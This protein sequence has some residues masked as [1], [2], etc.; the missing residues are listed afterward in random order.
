MQII[1]TLGEPLTF[2]TPLLAIATW[3]G[4]A[5][6]EQL[7]PLV[8]VGDW[9]SRPK[10]TL[11]LYPRGAI[12]AKRLLLLGLG[13]RNEATTE[14]L[15]EAGA[16]AAQQA[17]ELG[18]PELALALPV[19]ELLDPAVVSQALAEGA[20]LGQYRFNT[21]RTG[22]S[23]EQT[24]SVETLTLLTQS[25]T[26]GYERGIALAQ[27]IADGTQLARDL[28]NR[29][30]N[31]VVPAVLGATAEELGRHYGF[32]VTVLGRAE[33][34]AE[35]FGGIIGVGKGSANEPRF[36]VIEHGEKRAGVPTVCLVGKG[37]TFDT[38]GISIKPA[39]RMDEMKTD[40]SGAAAVLGTMRAIGALKLPL[41]VVGLI[42]SAEN[43]PSSTAYKP[44]DILTALSG[45]TIE[46]LNTDAEGRIV[47]ADA[48]FY[49]QRF[50]PD[51][52]IDLA[53]L[54]GAIVVALGTHATGMVTNSDT[55]AARLSRAGDATNERVWRMPL[56][57]P[58]LEQ[59][60]S[61]VAD[62]KN[63]GGRPGG[64]LTAAAFLSQFVGAYPWA[65]LDIAGTAYSD[66]SKRS[67]T[68]KGATGV[69]VRL[70]TQMLLD[71]AAE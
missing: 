46:V 58:Y 12:G 41:H 63:T 6:P 22:L 55:L 4:A 35:G 9:S 36:V 17:R 26:P 51:A 66:R 29:P 23:A 56:W 33:L 52:I 25:E 54:T 15:R 34:E 1:H 8:E 11:L 62:L 71:W 44:G 49:A 16:L 7:A 21:F 5:L 3:E 20:L 31:D 61:D 38:G 57:E 47:L 32:R 27:A 60:K 40:M 42:S 68:P 18:L 59:I 39:E 13:K 45:K 48:L 53:T 67:Y 14:R 65:H 28:V 50:A 30:G 43:M 2:A 19:L 64:A 37:I 24:R 69:G 10:Q 70:L